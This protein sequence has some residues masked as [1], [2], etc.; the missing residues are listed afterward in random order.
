MK[1]TIKVFEKVRIQ[2]ATDWVE[3][4]V[5]VDTGAFRTSIDRKLADE[6]GLSGEVSHQKR[7]KSALGVDVRDV[8]KLT[9]ELGGKQLITTA[10][11]ADRSNLRFQM[12]VG[13]QDLKDFLVE[14]DPMQERKG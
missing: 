8:I 10:S 4:E 9:F 12:I 11:L 13:R 14:C 7:V 5:K 6:L 1:K 2:T 3:I